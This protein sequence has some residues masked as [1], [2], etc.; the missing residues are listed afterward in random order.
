MIRALAAIVVAAGVVAGA[1]RAPAEEVVL[2]LSQD[3]IA[4]TATFEGS[5]I[6]VFGAVKRERPIP[7]GA[8]L[9]VVVTVTGPP[10]SVEMRRKA[11]RYGIWVNVESVRLNRVPSFYAVAS[12]GPVDEV[13][14]ATENLRH[15]VSLDHAIRTVGAASATGDVAAFT[16]AL[17]RVRAREGLYQVQPGAVAVDQQ[18]LFRTAVDLPA[19]LVEGNYR[20][21]I[22]LVREGAV[23]DL[24]QTNIDVRK[25]GLERW[26]FNL[27]HEMPP[28]YGALALAI[29]V[30]S[31]WLA[32]AVFRLL[33]G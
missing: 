1:A 30:A 28:V 12:T 6:L 13:L 27:A 24:Y 20:T 19:K 22:F 15:R 21:R 8:P 31:G 4:I 23:V 3:A 32:S 26:L 11:R 17:V 2:G 5:R 25:V 18:T 33:R 10:Q 29:A 14:S 16:E 7:A 9:D